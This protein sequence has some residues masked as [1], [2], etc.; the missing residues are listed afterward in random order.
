MTG[1]LE[2]N[3]GQGSCPSGLRTQSVVE[4]VSDRGKRPSPRIVGFHHDMAAVAEEQA[5]PGP[6]LGPIG[7]TPLFGLRRVLSCGLWS[8]LH[9]GHWL[10]R[11]RKTREDRLSRKGSALGMST[12][13]AT[14]PTAE[15]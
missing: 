15:Q 14:T 12:A 11:R 6:G 9:P 8:G 3:G 13:R 2:P 1:W 5:D 10:V 7:D 4:L